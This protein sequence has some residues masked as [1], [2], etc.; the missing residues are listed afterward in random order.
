MNLKLWNTQG[1]ILEQKKEP[2]ISRDLQ[3]L[4]SSQP[5]AAAAQPLKEGEE[6]E[7]TLERLIRLCEEASIID[8]RDGLPLA[9]ILRRWIDRKCSRI[10]GDAID[11]EPYVSSQTNPM[12]KLSSDAAYGL[13]LL[14]GALKPKTA[15]F[16]VY[17]EMYYLNCRVPTKIEEF[18]VRKMGGKYP[19]ERR[20]VRRLGD[21]V[22]TVGVCALIHL[23]RA[24]KEG[25]VQSSCFVTVAGNCIGNPSNLEVTIGTPVSALLD[26]CGLI[27]DPTVICLGS[28]MKGIA[29]VDA[30]NTLVR[31]NTNAVIAL[32][33]SK[34]NL[35]HMDCIGCA[36]CLEV[37]P[38]GL[39][40]MELYRAVSTNRRHT[41][42]TLGLQRCIGC[43]T[44]SY[45][46][47]SRLELS[48]R[49]QT[50]KMKWSTS[51]KHQKEG[52]VSEGDS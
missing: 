45:I 50:K 47:P 44:C 1:V 36:R 10:I 19:M 22:L 7:V 5:A 20:A 14:T 2:A 15:E 34:K 29:V 21:N 17:R 23:A 6:Q 13:R 11:E 30:D 8:E 40:P 9:D 41:A 18:V 12:M 24:A 39:N 37:C 16:A 25:T 35:R 46:C 3:Q 38:E 51:T 31:P 32:R 28:A 33:E 27:S 42:D 49:F 4:F 26:R 52:E 43:A 48:D